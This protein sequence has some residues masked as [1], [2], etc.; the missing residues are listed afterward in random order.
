MTIA[1]TATT[2]TSTRPIVTRTA[3]G[4]LAGSAALLLTAAGSAQAVPTAAA[5]ASPVFLSAHELPPH[6]S[7]PWYAGEVTAGLPENPMFC[8][9][10]ALPARGA[11][12]REFSTE[13]DTWALQI[14]VETGH[15]RQARKIVGQA[16]LAVQNCA[17]KYAQQH[18]GG[19]AEW[20]D[21]GSLPVENGAD[22]YG[23]ATRTDYGA[24]DVNLFGIGRDGRTVTV[25]RWARLGTF[26]HAEVEP[27]KDTVRAAV[28]KLY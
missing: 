14:V 5:T 11:S 10:G 17:E 6:P 24:N 19:S 25:I 9:E 3:A 15:E 4:L 21:Y 20:R 23:V 18:P 28:A 1:T 13:Y 26:E 7:S 12:H 22:V 8:V 16:R 27:F 2:A